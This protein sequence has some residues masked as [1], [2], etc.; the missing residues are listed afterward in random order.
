MVEKLTAAPAPLHRIPGSSDEP[1]VKPAAR[2]RLE[3]L[4]AALERDPASH[5]LAAKESFSD[6]LL[7]AP[8]VALRAI[9]PLSMS[10]CLERGPG[11][12]RR[13]VL[14]AAQR[15]RHS[16]DELGSALHRRKA[17]APSRMSGNCMNCRKARIACRATSITSATSPA[18]SN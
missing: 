7:H 4:T 12:H 9:R 1:A 13:I 17:A 10:A 15:L 8:V 11:G 14:L 3:A 5:G 18:M 16:G 6:F 2:R